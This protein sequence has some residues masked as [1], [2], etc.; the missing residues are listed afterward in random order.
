MERYQEIAQFLYNA[1]KERREVTRITAEQFPE[2]SVDDAYEIQYELVKLKL[3]EGRKIIGLKM[4]LTSQA[5]MR[6]MNV[7]EPIYGHLFDDM[8]VEDG[9]V[10]R[11]SELIHPRVEL[12]IAF[13]LGRDLS[14]PGVTA[15]HVMAATQYVLPAL[16]II[17]SR[18]EAFKFTLPDVIADNAS[19]S[20]L[21]LGS[22][23]TPPH[24]QELDVAGATLHINGELVD[25]GAGAAVLGHP[26][27]AVA[28][29]ANMLSRRGEGLKAGQIILSGGITGAA[30]LKGGDFVRA[31]IAG[32]GEVSFSVVEQ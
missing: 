3:K 15:A 25:L 18:Y 27:N 8:P 24:K 16:E 19:S 7:F 1:E 13:I 6:Q 30:S 20:R 31:R 22:T 10:I 21:V 32:L 9:G 28:K 23:L 29:L 17:D 2:M 14:G 26:A 4:G 5:K 11:L 12:E